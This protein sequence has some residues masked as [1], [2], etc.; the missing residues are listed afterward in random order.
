MKR[1]LMLG[2]AGVAIAAGA[3]ML[4]LRAPAPASEQFRNSNAYVPAP[5]AQPGWSRYENGA[6]S[7]PA[8]H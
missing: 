2:V 3:G 5:W 8:G 7:A 1:Y 4:L 6:M